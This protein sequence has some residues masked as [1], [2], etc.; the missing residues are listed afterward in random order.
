MK[1]IRLFA[2]LAALM[3]SS[4]A[5]AAA[6]TVSP[7]SELLKGD[8]PNNPDGTDVYCLVGGNEYDKA[9]K[10]WTF[11]ELYKD[12]VGGSESGTFASSYS[13][14][15]FNTPTDPEDATIKYGS[16]DSITCTQTDRCYL[17]VKDGNNDPIWYIF[18]I[19]TWDGTSAIE[20]TDFWPSNGAI[21]HVAIYGGSGGTY[22]VPEPG[23]LG[24]LGLGLFGMGLIK[25]KKS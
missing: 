10:S 1:T 12:N 20:M 2:A 17:V 6:Y 9:S 11:E 4:T 23:T 19:S 21:S 8:V 3:L 15:Y 18:D 24:L 5:F 7:G 13:T 22:E 16:G 14:E 25:R